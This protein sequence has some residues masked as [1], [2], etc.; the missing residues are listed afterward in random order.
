MNSSQMAAVAPEHEDYATGWYNRFAR[1]PYYGDLGIFAYQSF[2][3]IVGCQF[4]WFPGL[5]SGV[6]LMNLTRMRQFKWEEYVIPI[7][8]EYKSKITWGDQDILNIIFHFH[9][10][11]LYVYPCHY[12]YRPDHCMYMSVCKSAEENGAYV[13]HGNRGSFHSDKQPAFHAIYTSIKE[14][15]R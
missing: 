2:A 15:S 9:P 10:E 14:V 1:H 13:V 8:Q 6:M 5:N 4:I 12:N 11:K 3:N 7:Y